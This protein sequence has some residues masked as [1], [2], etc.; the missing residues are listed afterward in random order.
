MKEL[1]QAK[2]EE[3]YEELIW[4]QEHSTGEDRKK[5]EDQIRAVFQESIRRAQCT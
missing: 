4:R 2:L 1:T 5:I 3:L